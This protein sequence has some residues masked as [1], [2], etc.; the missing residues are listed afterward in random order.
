MCRYLNRHLLSFKIATTG[1]RYFLWDL[2]IIIAQIF[3]DLRRILIQS[4]YI[5]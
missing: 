2:H 4:A 1:H 5:W 3:A